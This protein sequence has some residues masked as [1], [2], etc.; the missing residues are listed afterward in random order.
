MGR[1]GPAP[2]PTAL[3][4]LLGNPG[5]RPLPKGDPR[6]TPGVPPCPSW[7]EGEARKEWRRITPELRAL[8]LLTA[9]DRAALAAYCQSYARWR[10]AEE[11][12]SRRGLVV[13]LAKLGK[14]GEAVVYAV[15]ARP[16]G[17]I[18]PKGR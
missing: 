3:K 7:L 4:L 15:P 14:A 11:V 8:G 16:G 9:V 10:Q 5:K 18:P 13:E 2:T 17:G 6:P 1:R 12:L